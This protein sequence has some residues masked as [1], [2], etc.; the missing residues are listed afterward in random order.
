MFWIASRETYLNL[1][2]KRNE[3]LFLQWDQKKP[4]VCIGVIMQFLHG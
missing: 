3:T 1:S 4:A 2:E